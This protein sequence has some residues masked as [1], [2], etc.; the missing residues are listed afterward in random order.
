MKK[1]A[2]KRSE[3]KY[4]LTLYFRNN[5]DDIVSLFKLHS[6]SIQF[7]YMEKAKHYFFSVDSIDILNEEQ[8]NILINLL[9]DFIAVSY[10]KN[11]FISYTSQYDTG[12]IF[13]PE[14][15]TEI[16]Y[17]LKAPIWVSIIS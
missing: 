16:S 15:V 14:I 2:V 17:K 5:I 4:G 9:N 11:V 1:E 3:I 12:N 10:D 8:K 13:V 7:G 6:Y